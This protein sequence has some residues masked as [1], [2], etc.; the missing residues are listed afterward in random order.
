MHTLITGA[1]SGIGAALARVL[2]AE[3]HRL[4]LVARRESRLKA[5]AEEVPGESVVL[6]F[7]LSELDSIPEL[8]RRAEEASGPVDILVN[9]AGFQAVGR[10]AGLSVEAIE[11]MVTIDLR[12][13]YR[14]SLA[15][16]PGM[17]ER[18]AGMIVDVSSLAGLAPMPGM[19]HYCGVKAGLAATSEA[20]RAELKPLGVH[21][22]TVYPGP[23]D[24]DMSRASVERYEGNP[25]KWGLP[26]G[27]PDTL[28]RLI[29]RAM[30][31]RRDRLTYPRFYALARWFPGLTR[32]ALDRFTPLPRD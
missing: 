19:S 13:P 11:A 1:S 12:A 25:L 10:V 16:I 14:L 20:L 30:K 3:G 4:S 23:V 18:G 15:V 6:P 26:L 29:A 9:N 7:D 5:L 27:D 21:V 8:V 31:K 22:L 2:A 28:A 32:W 17:V 24:T